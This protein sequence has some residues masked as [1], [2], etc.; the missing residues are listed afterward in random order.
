MA[1]PRRVLL[2][3]D[4]EDFRTSLADLLVLWGMEV[5]IADDGADALAL[6]EHDPLPDI[7]LL[8]LWMPGLDGRSVLE[9]LRASPRLAQL[10]VIA[11]TGAVPRDD[12]RVPYLLKPF[13]VEALVRLI[14]DVMGDR[15]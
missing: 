8:D 3:D 4:Y 9:A 12:L 14:A 15:S 7:L 1:G 13:D 10:R 5:Q 6:L 2:V 11:V